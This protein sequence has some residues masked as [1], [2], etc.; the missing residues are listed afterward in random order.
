MVL[1]V[2]S[3]SVLLWLSRVGAVALR[4][5]CGGVYG[6]RHVG[7]R[8]RVGARDWREDR[9]YK[10][11]ALRSSGASK[12]HG[13]YLSIFCF[14]FSCG[15][16][17]FSFSRCGGSLYLHGLIRVDVFEHAD[18][19]ILGWQIATVLEDTVVVAD[20][21]EGAQLMNDNKNCR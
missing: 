2:C 13:S 17:Y 21:F 4:A 20:Q 6:L 14:F 8:G 18:D 12:D 7:R 19:M 11:I 5:R 10:R 9:G 1:S 16:G 15:Y 3:A